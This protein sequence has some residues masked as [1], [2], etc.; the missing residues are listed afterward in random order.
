LSV[1]CEFTHGSFSRREEVLDDM[2]EGRLKVLIATSILDEGV[3]V[4]GINCLWMAAGGKSFRQVLQRIGRGLRKK[5]DGS[6]LEVYDFLD[7]TQKHLI[8]HTQERYT[9]YKNEGFEIKK[10]EE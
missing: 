10:V 3:D 2:K 4:S 8:K 5:D 7:Y 1:E 9:Y 6:G